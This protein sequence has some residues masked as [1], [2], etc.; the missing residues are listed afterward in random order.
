MFRWQPKSRSGSN[1]VSRMKSSSHARASNFIPVSG[2]AL[3][4]AAISLVTF[5]TAAAEP[6]QPLTPQEE[7]ASFRLADP[8]LT[9]ELAAAEPEVLSPVAIAFDPDGRLLV[10]EMFDY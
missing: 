6:S 1:S 3:G 8:A 7:R 5:A 9:I 4:A 2:I 10:A